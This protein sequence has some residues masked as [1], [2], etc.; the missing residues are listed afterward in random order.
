MSLRADLAHSVDADGQLQPNVPTPLWACGGEAT[1][2]T[3]STLAPPIRGGEEAAGLVECTTARLR[4]PRGEERVPIVVR[5]HTGDRR[6]PGFLPMME[7]CRR[8]PVD[9][10]GRCRGIAWDVVE[11]D[12]QTMTRT[13]KMT[14]A[15]RSGRRAQVH[16]GSK[17]KEETVAARAGDC[18]ALGAPCSWKQRFSSTARKTTTRIGKR[19]AK[20]EDRKEDKGENEKE[21]A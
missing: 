20:E 19:T 8:E 3:S 21:A 9:R 13:M 17:L 10:G 1:T 11:T 14:A 15:K 6:P 18:G 16:Q 12:A 7:A 5:C 2:T 4:P